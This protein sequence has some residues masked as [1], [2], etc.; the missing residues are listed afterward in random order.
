MGKHSGNNRIGVQA[1]CFSFV[2]KY[3]TVPQDGIRRRF[4]VFRTDKFPAGEQGE[5]PGATVQGD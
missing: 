2:G 1:V 3:N 5:Y 4:Y